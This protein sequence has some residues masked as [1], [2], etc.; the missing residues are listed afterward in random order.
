MQMSPRGTVWQEGIQTL[1]NSRKRH[2]LGPVGKKGVPLAA[3]DKP[4]VFEKH[5]WISVC[6]VVFI[7]SLTRVFDFAIIPPA[8][9]G[10]AITQPFYGLHS[11]GKSGSHLHISHSG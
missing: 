1:A 10:L 4:S 7:W 9:N 3:E 11:W 5:F 6:G 8:Y 2:C